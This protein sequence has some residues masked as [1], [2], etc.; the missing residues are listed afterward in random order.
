[1]RFLRRGSAD[2]GSGSDFWSWWA[3]GRDRVA[4]AIEAGAFDQRLVADIS[5][6]VEGVQRG[7]AW[8]LGQGAG[9]R[10]AFC[11]S[12]EG[13]PELRQAALRWLASA[14]PADETWEY[15]AS[16]QPSAALQGL[17]IGDQR[18]DLEEMRTIASWDPARR[19]LD[20]RVWHPRFEGAPEQTRVQ[21]AFL[22][23]DNLLG[24]DDVER[25][26]GQ[27]DLLEAPSGGL[28]PAEL[29][30]EVER[31]KQDADGNDSWVLGGGTRPDGSRVVVLA[32]AGLKRIDHPFADHH[33]TIAIVFGGD[34]MPNDSEAERLNEWEDDF[35]GRIGEAAVYA[36]R[37]T[38]PGIRTL[39]LVAVDPE[40]LRPA[41]DAWA[42]T[43]PD[44]F[45]DGYPQ[46]RL[47]VNFERDM[48]W[49]FQ[50][51]L[52]VR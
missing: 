18:F 45:A 40:A 24:E 28:T 9:A 32:H 52:G 15:H 26:V 44:W 34:R 49:S 10:H 48:D 17:D 33:V 25:W 35:L 29:R 43:L 6:A 20:V 31:H 51:D 1:M 22:F 23:L 50:R 16:R 27:I 5:R 46:M 47:K 41:I 8:E 39:H 38:E 3:T 37:E 7:M 4:A 14:P 42:E 30:A 12:P 36:G 11:V 13:N 19:R 21:V 2:A